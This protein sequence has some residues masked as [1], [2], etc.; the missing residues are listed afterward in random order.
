MAE[1]LWENTG[2]RLTLWGPLAP[3]GL[4]LAALVFG[5]DQ[6]HKYWMLHVYH[7][8]EK[9]LVSLT[10]FLDLVLA[11]NQGVSYGLLKSNTQG[12]LIGISV[13]ISSVLWVWLC[14]SH[15]PLSAAALGLVIGGA[16]GNALDRYLYG[17]VADFFHLHWGNLSWYVFNVADIAIVAGV[18]LLLY[19]SMVE[20]N[21][22]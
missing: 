15:R 10:P 17:A 7:I 2:M 13:I 11:W 21:A 3:L 8:N 22:T 9:V 6:A 16:L 12:L 20:R 14:R 5:L 19:E 4:A 1:A 18:G